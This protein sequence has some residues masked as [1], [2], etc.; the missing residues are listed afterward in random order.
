VQECL[1]N[2]NIH[3][4]SGSPKAK[5]RI[6]CSDGLVLV[7][8][9]D[10]GKGIPIDRLIEMD[11]PGPSGVGVRGMRERIRQLGGKLDIKSGTKGTTIRVG[12]PVANTLSTSAALSRE[13]SSIVRGQDLVRELE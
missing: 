6:A 12:L 5:I 11:S 8:V 10:E 4:H 13:I 9:E 3:R 7:E 1:T 2:T